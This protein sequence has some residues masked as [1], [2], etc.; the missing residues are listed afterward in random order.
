MT[1]HEQHRVH[2]CRGRPSDGII[3]LHETPEWLCGS[4]LH[5]QSG[6]VVHRWNPC[7]GGTVPLMFVCFHV[8][9][10]LLS[11]HNA[12]CCIMHAL[13]AVHL[14]A[15]LSLC[16]F[17]VTR[18]WHGSRPQPTGPSGPPSSAFCSEIIPPTA[19][20]PPYPESLWQ[21]QQH[22][23]SSQPVGRFGAGG[24][25][26]NSHVPS[27]LM[28]SLPRRPKSLGYRC[29]VLANPQ[30]SRWTPRKCWQRSA[31]RHP[32]A[33]SIP[34][35]GAADKNWALKF[36]GSDAW[37]VPKTGILLEGA[38]GKCNTAVTAAQLCLDNTTL[39][40]T[41]YLVPNLH[42]CI[43]KTFEGSQF[44]FIIKLKWNIF[45]YFCLTF[46][47]LAIL[48]YF[49]FHWLVNTNS[50]LMFSLRQTK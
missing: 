39:C 6:G 49:S 43:S 19:T 47:P 44:S 12:R 36:G 34:E 33:S 31:A 45:S 7:F 2:G 9:Y 14:F 46:P 13:T 26:P 18:S 48:F 15:L 30:I 27:L 11:A 4:D 40:P 22:R 23:R 17:L 16:V 20:P 5:S 42:I 37:L 35:T 24:S 38:N 3:F 29:L 50:W 25:L 10:D 41:N 28:P 21:R 1:P 32:K 8:M